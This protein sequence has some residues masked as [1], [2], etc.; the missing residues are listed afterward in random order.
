V[1]LSYFFTGSPIH[2][3]LGALKNQQITFHFTV[4][5]T[6]LLHLIQQPQTPWIPL[7]QYGLKN[8]IMH[9]RAKNTKDEHPMVV[10][11]WISK[12]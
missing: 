11:A 3:P 6:N 9:A 5:V 2:P 4:S 7:R 1:L 12:S 10:P 8:D